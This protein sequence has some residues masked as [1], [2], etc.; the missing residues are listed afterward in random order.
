MKLGQT[1]IYWG[2]RVS[3]TPREK[4]LITWGHPPMPTQRDAGGEVVKEPDGPDLDECVRGILALF[5]GVPLAITTALGL[6]VALFVGA[7]LVLGL[8]LRIVLSVL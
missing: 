1:D 8:F 5:I 4:T 6:L 2:S 3:D 7:A